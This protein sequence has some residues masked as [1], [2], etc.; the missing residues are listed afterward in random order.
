M[1]PPT[2]TVPLVT[3]DFGM[4]ARHPPRKRI[5][6]VGNS[7]PRADTAVRPYADVPNPRNLLMN[8]RLW[9]NLDRQAILNTNH[10]VGSTC[11]AVIMRDHD[12][13]NTRFLRNLTHQLEYFRT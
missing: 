6:L 8:H 5:E 1:E 4:S 10:T 13:R 7:T 2:R 9:V 12:K 3:G 11:Q